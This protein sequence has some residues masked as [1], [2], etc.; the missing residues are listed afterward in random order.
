MSWL[1]LRIRGPDKS[2]AKNKYHGEYPLYKV[3]Y[4]LQNSQ[5][6]HDD[7]LKYFQ[8]NNPHLTIEEFKKKYPYPLYYMPIDLSMSLYHAISV[9]K[10]GI[11]RLRESGNYDDSRITLTAVVGNIERIKDIDITINGKHIDTR[12]R[13]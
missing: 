7:I 3:R 5:R 4:V 11:I 8:N 2:K 1:K 6:L 12:R 10:D 13:K 9:G